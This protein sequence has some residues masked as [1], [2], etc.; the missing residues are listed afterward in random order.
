MNKYR[1]SLDQ[2]NQVNFQRK[3]INKGVIGGVITF[4]ASIIPSL[5][6]CNGIDLTTPENVSATNIPTKKVFGVRNKEK[7]T[8]ST[9]ETIAPFT[10][11]KLKT[12]ATAVAKSQAP[13]ETAKPAETEKPTAVETVAPLNINRVL[14]KY[15]REFD[16]TEDEKDFLESDEVNALLSKYQDKTLAKNIIRILNTSNQMNNIARSDAFRLEEDKDKKLEFSAFDMACFTAYLNDYFG[17]DLASIFGDYIPSPRDFQ[18]GINNIRY[19]LTVLYMNCTEEVDYS[20]IV[21]DPN[22]LD[23]INTFQRAMINNNRKRALGTR[24][25]EDIDKIIALKYKLFDTNPSIPTSFELIIRPMLE[26][27]VAMEANINNGENLTLSKTTNGVPA[28]YKIMQEEFG[29]R[30]DGNLVP[31]LAGQA[32]QANLDLNNVDCEDRDIESINIAK[33][34]DVFANSVL[35]SFESIKHDIVM[36][37]VIVD[38]QY[39]KKLDSLSMNQFT[40]EVL[41]EL[42]EKAE[43][44]FPNLLDLV[45]SLRERVSNGLSI[46]FE[47]ACREI[48]A[49]NGL[50]KEENDYQ[51]L[52][53]NRRE[54][55]GVVD[56][57]SYK[58]NP[59][60]KDQKNPKNKT[61]KKKEKIDKNKIPEEEKEK[62]E[63]EEEKQKKKDKE[64]QEKQREEHEKGKDAVINAIEQGKSDDEIQKAGEEHGFK[65]DPN[66]KENYKNAKE[67]QKNG[68]EKKKQRE[69]EMKKNT[70]ENKK[71][72]DEDK[73]RERQRQRKKKE[74]MDAKIKESQNLNKPSN[75]DKPPVS[76]QTTHNLPE[77][78]EI[79]GN[80][81]KNKLLYLRKTLVEA[82]GL[83]KN[84]SQQVNKT[85]VR[86][87]KQNYNNRV[88]KSA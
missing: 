49:I 82:F 87:A 55:F 26:G 38:P 13:T 63:K 14:S 81:I 66:A 46:G 71:K 78:A 15:Y 53:N 41:D 74:E 17:E 68:E 12:P 45:D 35:N 18:N 33:S 56:E 24:T 58:S 10:T 76:D 70:E 3:K 29:L 42:E 84:P 65:A 43:E 83:D 28:G 2:N 32:H 5:S 47:E 21:D 25:R 31:I 40:D 51:S 88:N 75:T 8:P 4:F 64:N 67:E 1:F 61:E 52:I 60:S 57:K 69:E 23:V 79:V 54:A 19:A 72:S 22:E 36:S 30:S 59:G 7:N 27:F 73:E 34:L 20:D 6:N 9:T 37:I 50:D 80:N 44:S 86:T 11:E 77:G 85:F 16:S 48:D 39:G 62:V